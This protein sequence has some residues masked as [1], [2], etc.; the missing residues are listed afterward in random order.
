MKPCF[1]LIE[2]PFTAFTMIFLVAS[3][4]NAEE[5][6]E[7]AK[8]EF[9]GVP[10]NVRLLNNPK[11]FE[12]ITRNAGKITVIT[13]PLPTKNKT[14]IPFR[15]EKQTPEGRAIATGPII[16]VQ[17]GETKIDSRWVGR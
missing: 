12:K 4:A 5:V 7:K 11:F 9:R 2:S 10:S 6:K 8:I 14:P 16:E 15:F 17:G 1:R 13:K 3:M